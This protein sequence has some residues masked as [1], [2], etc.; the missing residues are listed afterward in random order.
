[1]WRRAVSFASPAARSFSSAC[2]RS[3]S[4]NR[5]ALRSSYPADRRRAIGPPGARACRESRPGKA[6]EAADRLGRVEIEPLPRTRPICGRALR[7]A[8]RGDRGSSRAPHGA[9]GGGPTGPRRSAARTRKQ[10]SSRRA[11]S[12]GDIMGMRATASSIAS[13]IP[14]S[15]RQMVATAST[16]ASV[17]RNL[18]S[19]ARTV[20][21]ETD[22]SD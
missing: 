18:M 3:G 8:P 13:G 22:A 2:W 12:A 5:V 14:S 17:S 11:I 10:S 19:R 9:S 6:A 21:E 15:C 4:S 20:H 7:S 1:M 16:F